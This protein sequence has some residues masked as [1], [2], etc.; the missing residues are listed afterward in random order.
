MDLEYGAEYDAFR[1]E[2][3]A[4]LEA[5]KP[6]NLAEASAEDRSAWLTKQIEHGYWA[7]TI[8][9]EYGGYGAEPN[10]LHTII[11]DEE[12]NRAGTLRGTP[13]QG[14]SMLVPT[15]L[16]HGT[17]EQKRRWIGPTMRGEVIWCQGYSEPGAGSD[18]AS[19]QTRAVADGDDFLI[20]GQKIWT[21]TADKSQM[22]F[23][24]VRTEADAPKH[25]GISYLLVPVDSPG[26]EVRPLRT[27]AGDLGPSSFNQVFFDEVRVPRSNVVGRRGEGWKIANTTLKHERN[28]LSSN[29]EGT[30][31]RLAKLMRDET[32]NGVP[33]IASPVYRDRLM[34]LQARMLSMKYH[35]LRMLTC[36]LKEE[37][38]GVAGLVAKLE[39]CQLSFDMAALALDVMG[40]LGALYD[41]AKYERA[42]GHWQAHSMFALGLII[43]GGTAQ[44]QKNIIAERGLGMPREPKPAKA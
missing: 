17:E 2:V 37:P 12:F 36:A 35:A 1:E 38:P 8:P 10:L 25:A 3:R 11:M 18:L 6:G 5:H 34:Q 28:S 13:S 24:L 43:G 23:A 41:H 20:S 29:A 39:N 44:I 33:A 26:L 40:E 32:M 4:F 30:W 27:M 15:L 21:S 9:T 14:P 31:M 7:R 16:E 19:L 22:M 42:R